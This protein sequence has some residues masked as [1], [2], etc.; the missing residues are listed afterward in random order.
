M[1][2]TGDNAHSLLRGVGS[3]VAFVFD[4]LHLAYPHC[5]IA[6]IGEDAAEQFGSLGEVAGKFSEKV[7]KRSI[8]GD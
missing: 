3:L 6:G 2:G 5:A 1:K 8:A 4:A 7:E